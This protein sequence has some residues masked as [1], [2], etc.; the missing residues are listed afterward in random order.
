MKISQE[1]ST[2]QATPPRD[3]A[4]DYPRP[5]FQVIG[6]IHHYL[7][8]INDSAGGGIV[9]ASTGPCGSDFGA[10]VSHLPPCW[11]GQPSG[12]FVPLA[13]QRI[14]KLETAL[15][16]KFYKGI[17]VRQDFNE[18][19]RWWKLAYGTSAATGSAWTTSSS[20]TGCARTDDISS[21]TPLS[22]RSWRRFGVCGTGVT[23]FA[24]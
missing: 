4:L 3:N 9:T 1:V 21:Q 17:D 14:A 23:P 24:A 6:R 5:A 15:E 10:F 13:Q 7:Y 16:V 22:R 11:I 8:L 20:A 19:V 12:A 18:A 2:P